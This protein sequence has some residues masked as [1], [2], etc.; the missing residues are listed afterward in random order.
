VAWRADEGLSRPAAARR[1]GVAHTTLR[2]WEVNS[3]CPQ[4]L[5]LRLLAEV[6][7]AEPEA[8]RALAGPDPIRTVRTSGG[9]D[10]SPLCRS[11]LAARLTMTQLGLKVGVVPA[12]ISR[13]ENGVRTPSPEAQARL[14]QALRVTPEELTVMLAGSRP[15]RSDGVLLPGLGQLRRELGLTQRAFRT[16]IGIGPSAANAW[17]HGRVR[18]PTGRLATV[19]GALGVDP[20]AVV[21]AASLPPRDRASDRP[22]TGLRRAAGLTQREM[23]HH[24]GAS[25]RSVAHWEAGTR[26]LP[27]PVARRLAA[28]L[29]IPLRTVLRAAERELPMLTHPRTWTPVD[30]PHVLTTLRCN[31]GW[32]AA[33]LARRL[34]TSGGVVRSWETAGVFPAASVCARL[35][36][37]YRLPR[38]VLTRL[39]PDDM[40]RRKSGQSSGRRGGDALASAAARHALAPSAPDRSART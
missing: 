17:E 32:S 3:V 5:Q 36:L 19:A 10:A 30:L 35:E 25:V 20:K 34:G 37:V 11:R 38:G 33:A 26:A 2:S 9:H 13:W 15:R 28:L 14:A 23:A 21:A 27:L 31:A 4:P 6:L 22:L 1:L 24:L 40:E 18:V 16:A 12:T 8:V 29:K 7:G 39:V